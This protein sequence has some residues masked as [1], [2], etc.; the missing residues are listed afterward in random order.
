MELNRITAAKLASARAAH[1][2]DL[3]LK[4][5]AAIPTAAEATK[6]YTLPLVC[7]YSGLVVGSLNVATVAGY[8][9]L[10]GQWK[11]TMILHPVFSL[12]E[13]ALVKFAKN[14]WF[15]F[16]AFN[17]LEAEDDNLTTKQETLLR[18]AALALL[19]KLTTFR[20]DQPWL[21]NWAAVSKNWNSLLALSYWK[22]Y[23]ESERFKFPSL[24]ISKLEPEI[25]L[26]VYLNLCWEVKK[27]YETKVNERV[28]RE[29]IESAE[30]ALKVL[31][32]DLAGKSP[33]SSKLLWRWFV[34]NLPARYEADSEGWM[35]TI[36]YSKDSDHLQNHFT[37]A[38]LDLFEQIFLAECPTGSS[39]SH[40]FLEILRGKRKILENHFETFEILVPDSIR[41]S[42]AAGEISAEEPKLKDFK[43]KAQWMIAHAKWRLA[44]RGGGAS[45]EASARKQATVTVSPTF[46][47]ELPY[48]RKT[49]LED[50]VD[51]IEEDDL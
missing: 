31:R 7:K 38:D 44:H 19:H 47:P 12:N 37:L 10:L 18:V 17:P 25:D 43:S 16:C 33:R 9:P 28:E 8:M 39:L 27:Q 50:A 2:N 15:R 49:K 1:A 14:A 5:I 20:Q 29:K 34:A 23:L 35:R 4:E 46:V 45:A 48:L 41:E 51:G 13:G 32:D 24:R 6:S 22:N 11:D 42:A 26:T 3:L 36:F 30:R 40:A 21:P